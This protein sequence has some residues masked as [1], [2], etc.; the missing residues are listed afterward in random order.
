M[1]A[2]P[3]GRGRGHRMGSAL[4]RGQHGQND[5][6]EQEQRAAG[7]PGPVEAVRYE[8]DDD[9]AGGPGRYQPPLLPSVDH[10]GREHL[11]AQTGPP[12]RIGV[13]PHGQHAVGGMLL[14][15]QPALGGRPRV[16]PHRGTGGPGAGTARL[17]GDPRGGRVA[18]RRRHHPE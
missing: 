3:P 15:A 7:E 13:L 8:V 4:A 9:L 5:D 6:Q 10:D 1:T 11:S 16:N 18:A 12:A 17:K 2:A 14:D